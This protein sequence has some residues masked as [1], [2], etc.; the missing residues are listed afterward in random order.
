MKLDKYV[1]KSG[2]KLRMGYTTGS[3]A[4]AAA[5]AGAIML[6]T[7]KPLDSVRITTPAGMTLELDIEDITLLRDEVS[8]CVIKDGGDNT[9]ATD[10]IK[11]FA[12]VRRADRAIKIE[13][14]AGVGRVTKKGLPCE[15]G[16]AA[17]NPVPLRTIKEALLE[18][19]RERKYKK[20]FTV[21]I[22]APAGEKVS[23]RTFN[24]RLGITGGISILGTTGLVEPMSEAA[25]VDSIKAEINMAGVNGAPVLMTPGHYGRHFMENSLGLDS[26]SAVSCS[27]FIGESL[28]YLV[29]KG[30]RK[31]L[32]VGHCGKLVKL[33]AAVFNTHSRMADCRNEI[34]AA[35]AALSGAGIETVKSVM[36]ATTTEAIDSI[37]TEKGLDKKVYPSILEKI[38]FNI[39]Y[40][41]KNRIEVEV[42]IFS[43][44]RGALMQ[45]EKAALLLE[46]IKRGV[47]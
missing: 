3:C 21:T 37:L 7:G 18:V 30:I 43:N 28:D 10:G 34:F 39:G 27:N 22:T 19:S 2:K 36:E 35:H 6:L 33:A 14:G 26:E 4:A 16:Q 17:I 29:Y 24:A 32:L 31:A 40:R 13:G 11:I 47:S 20:G 8:C 9:D 5:K 23:G 41:T 1:V 45:S 42:I 38:M 44:E 12:A 25:L 15:V 46:E